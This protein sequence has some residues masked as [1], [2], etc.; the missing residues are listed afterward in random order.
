[1][2]MQRAGIN[3]PVVDENRRVHTRIVKEYDGPMWIG[4]DTE[5]QGADEP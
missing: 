3:T 2:L 1:M 5:K 4:A